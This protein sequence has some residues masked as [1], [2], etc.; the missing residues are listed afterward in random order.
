MAKDKRQVM[1]TRAKKMAR[2]AAKK[3]RRLRA[4]ARN[5]DRHLIKYG[6]ARAEIRAA[7]F[8]RALVSQ[9]ID[10]QGMGY[11]VITRKLE[12]GRLASGT[13]L[14]DSYCLGVKDAF[15]R[16][17][18]PADLVDLTT[19]HGQQLD[20][21]TPAY[22]CKLVRDAI[23]YARALGFEPHA[24]YADVAILFDGVDPEA[25]DTEFTFGKDGKPF[26]INGPSHSLQKADA[27]IAHLTARLGKDGFH[28][29]IGGE[30]G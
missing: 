28:F 2:A 7:P 17:I 6:V 22:A 25:C 3:T 14:L 11:V 10:D 19:N 4:A 5:S 9:G 13:I 26:Y 30:V 24:D 16:I 15:F 18:A 12:N 23:A 8:D 29:L 1:Q 27:I 20:D 21:V